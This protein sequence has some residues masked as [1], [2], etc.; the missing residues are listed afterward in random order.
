[1]TNDTRQ[2]VDKA[3]SFAHVLRD[4][5]FSYKAIALSLVRA[6]RLR[7]S[8]LKQAFEGKPAPQDP[9]DEPASVLLERTIGGACGKMNGTPGAP[10]TGTRQRSSTKKHEEDRS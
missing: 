5:G 8:I 9:Q 10:R 4:D 6:S 7:Q 1:M 2:I 3:W